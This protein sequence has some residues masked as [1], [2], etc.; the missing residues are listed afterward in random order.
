MSSLF[1]GRRTKFLALVFWLVVVGLAGPLSGKLTDAQQNDVAD[2]KREVLSILAVEPDMELAFDDAV[3][4]NQVRCWTE[5]RRAM[6]WPDAGCHTPWSEE[7]GVQENA[8]GQM[9]H[10]QNVG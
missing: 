3:I 9:R 4:K 7:I 10:S 5:S 2:S 6:F 1:T 8:T